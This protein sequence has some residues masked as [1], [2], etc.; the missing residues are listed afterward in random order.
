[1]QRNDMQ[2]DGTGSPKYQMIHFLLNYLYDFG[3]SFDFSN[4]DFSNL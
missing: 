4:P 3:K 1:M 2:I